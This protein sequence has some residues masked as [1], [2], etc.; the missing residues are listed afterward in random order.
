MTKLLKLIPEGFLGIATQKPIGG[1]TSNIVNRQTVREEEEP[2]EKLDLY[3]LV[4]EPSNNLTKEHK[5]AF[6]EAVKRYNEYSDSIY[7]NHDLKEISQNIGALGKLAEKIA[8]NEQDD[9]FDGMTVKRDMKSLQD[10]VKVFEATCKE[11]SQLQH[12]LESMYEECGSKLG[13]YFEIG[14]KNEQP[15]TESKKKVSK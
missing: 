5:K 14:D 12:R 11:M 10:S 6:L 2:K 3:T 13:K 9:W 1:V 4:T 15:V 8:V 7:R